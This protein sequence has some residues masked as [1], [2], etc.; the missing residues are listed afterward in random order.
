MHSLEADET[1]I[2]CEEEIGIGTRQMREHIKGGTIYGYESRGREMRLGE[3]FDPVDVVVIGHVSLNYPTPSN[4]SHL[5]TWGIVTEVLLGG[6]QQTTRQGRGW[7]GRGINKYERSAQG[8]PRNR[9]QADDTINITERTP[10]G[11]LGINL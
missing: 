7:H 5:Y 8:T 3:E 9:I 4:D 11:S 10:L 2:R 1:T 6:Y